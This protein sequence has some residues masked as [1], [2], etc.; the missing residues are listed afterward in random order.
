MENN[1]N[2][3]AMVEQ[4]QQQQHGEDAAPVKQ[5]RG[6]RKKHTTTGAAAAA[7]TA[8]GATATTDD[9][10]TSRRRRKGRPP[11]EENPAL[12]KV[13]EYGRQCQNLPRS[14]S[15]H[16]SFRKDAKKAGMRFISSLK[17]R[18]KRLSCAC[19]ENGRCAVQCLHLHR[20]P[21]ATQRAPHPTM[22]ST[23]CNDSA[24]LSCFVPDACRTPFSFATY[25]LK[26][27]TVP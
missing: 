7:K 10:Q 19:F 1:S 12:C 22:R 5:T 15:V 17:A 13:V 21:H 2:K 25:T 4:Q 11:I 26:W 16:H 6:R 20:H 14:Q 9:G 24:P 3:V 27:L 23:L 18:V 8:S